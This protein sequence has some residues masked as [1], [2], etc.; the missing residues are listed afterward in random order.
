MSS[1]ARKLIVIVGIICI[2]AA[3]VLMIGASYFFNIAINRRTL[4]FIEDDSPNELSGPLPTP[5]DVRGTNWVE[6]KGYETWTIKS[7]DGLFLKAYFVKAKKDTGKT[8]ILA[9]GYSSQ[10]KDM[11][12]FAKFYNEKLGFNVLMPDDRGHGQSQGDYIGFG[13][14]DRLD[15]LQWINKVVELVGEDA[16]IVLH[17]VSMGGATV[18][19]VSGE[20]LPEQVKAIIEDCGYTSVHD[21]LK[22]QLKQLYNLPE[23]P[24]LYATSIMT[25]IRAGYT[26]EEASAINQ[27]KKNRLPILFIHGGE[28][29]FVPTE[30]V[31]QLYEACPS[32]KEL[33]IVE[34]AGHAMSYTKD[35]KGYKQT[36]IT[37]LK[38]HL[39]K[40]K[41]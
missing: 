25:K 39:K 17:G 38:K 26:F 35:K 15:Y 2:I 34:N 12:S 1:N 11:G 40:N 30:M 33:Y 31:Y 20:E 28:D 29:T 18:M 9:H 22:Y 16:R 10:G 7:E 32:E 6:D 23:F 3:V 41:K 14:L 21:Q 5:I 36:V 19:M 37:F 27:L 13:W 8:V 4:L 24:F